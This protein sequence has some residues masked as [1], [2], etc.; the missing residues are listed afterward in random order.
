MTKIAIPAAGIEFDVA[1]GDTI[2][3]AATRAGLGFPY[4]CNVGECGNCRFELLEGE[5]TYLREN[6]P[7]LN[8]KD[9]QRK[10]YLGCQAQPKGPCQIKVPMRDHYK[11][12]HLPVR[13]RGTLTEVIGI[14]HD[15]REF[16]FAVENPAA[17]LPGQYA[18]IS[19]PGVEGARAYSMCNITASGEEWHFQIRKVPNGKATGSLF[20]TLQIGGS[21]GLDGPFGMAYLRE[22]APRD[23]LLLG[24][25]SG[26]SPMISIA[27]G[28]AQSAALKDRHIH[29]IY[30]GRTPRDICGED[31]LK[32]LP[33]WGERIHYTPAISVLDDHSSAGW[34]G[35]TGFVPDVAAKLF[36]EDLS[37]FEV[38]FAGPPMM[39]QSVMRMLIKGK[40]PASQMH[41]DQFY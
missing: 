19:A 25:G 40:V 15:I 29:F 16:R 28:A 11:S 3:R 24:G 38:Y 41:F 33:G 32:V 27:R 9:L 37:R 26:L 14:T 31:M 22:D 13:T 21:V 10:R 18:L 23:I 39:A 7:A 36:G 17:F 5:V 2:A 8:E 35:E 20:D 4:E 1:Q 34:T 30:G 6:P 12:K